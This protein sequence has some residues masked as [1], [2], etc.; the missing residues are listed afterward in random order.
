MPFNKNG[1]VLPFFG[2]LQYIII[3]RVT[4]NY[5]DCVCVCVYEYIYIYIHTHTHTHT[6]TILYN[7]NLIRKCVFYKKIIA[8]MFC[9]SVLGKTL[10]WCGSYH[11]QLLV[12]YPNGTVFLCCQQIFQ[13][14][15]HQKFLHFAYYC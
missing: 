15:S 7:D 13:N 6:H 14:K 3:V 8:L 2:L 5:L 4:D 10:L 1:N 11:R 9:F 12:Y